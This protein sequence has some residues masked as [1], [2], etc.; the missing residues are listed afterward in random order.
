MKKLLAGLALGTA[1]LCA[2]TPT[3]GA[4]P[5][6]SF[7]ELTAYLGLTA[8]EITSLQAVQTS[9]QAQSKTYMTQINTDR[10]SLDA[11]LAGKS[12]DPATIGNLEIDIYNNQAKI[13]A[14][15]TSAY[16]QA[17]ALLTADQRTKLAA[18]QAASDLSPTI[19]EA[20]MLNL[21]KPSTTGGG[22]GPRRINPAGR[23][24]MMGPG[25]PMADRFRPGR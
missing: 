16:N 17:I 3:A 14:L 1:L 4:P 22:F 25:A 21:L 18:L 11:L 20:G 5:T 2:Q 24:G 12:P 6:P 13:N 19:H 10:T 15:A 23:P 9:I 8:A 7:T